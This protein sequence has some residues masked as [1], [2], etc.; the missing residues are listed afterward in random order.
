MT[1]RTRA[2]FTVDITFD[3][4]IEGAELRRYVR[5]SI[6]ESIGILWHDYMVNEETC[7]QAPK[8]VRV[9]WTKG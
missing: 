7:P 8:R 4:P 2:T 9:R 6:E 5:N 1:K 3:K